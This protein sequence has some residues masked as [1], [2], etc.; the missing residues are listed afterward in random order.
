MPTALRPSRESPSAAW[1]MVGA[2]QVAIDGGT[3]L[4]IAWQA[5][6]GWLMG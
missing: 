2:L 1:I 5:P 6:P 4:P 3:A